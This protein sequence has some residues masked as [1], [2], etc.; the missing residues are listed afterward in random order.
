MIAIF[1]NSR[2]RGE[3]DEWDV[4]HRCSSLRASRFQHWYFSG[5]GLDWEIIRLFDE[6]VDV[7]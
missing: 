7:L 1:S 5:R 2:G 3:L 4:T 6:Q